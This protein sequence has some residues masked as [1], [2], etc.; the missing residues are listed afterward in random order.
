VNDPTYES[1]AERAMFNLWGHRSSRTGL[2]GSAIDI[3][4][5]AWVNPMAGLGAG[6]DS[7]YEYAL[8]VRRRPPVI[9]VIHSIN[10]LRTFCFAWMR[11]RQ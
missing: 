8:K 2:L 6:L 4:T 5:G 10:Q 1:V 11:S 7:F 9:H 3:H